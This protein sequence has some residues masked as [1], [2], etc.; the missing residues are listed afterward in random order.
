MVPVADQVSLSVRRSTSQSRMWRSAWATARVAPSAMKA[1][2]RI[3]GSSARPHLPLGR[4]GGGIVQGELAAPG[5]AELAPRRE[6]DPR[7]QPGVTGQAPDLV[8]PVAIPD[9]DDSRD[10]SAWQDAAVRG[11]GEGADGF[12]V[13]RVE[14]EDGTQRQPGSIGPRPGPTSR[15]CR[16]RPVSRSHTWTLPSAAPA[17]SSRPSGR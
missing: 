2:C 13:D 11:E 10:C 16:T 6:A 15:R 1:A 17:A 14:V 5:D 3:S 8:P 4:P 7:R 9:R 12:G